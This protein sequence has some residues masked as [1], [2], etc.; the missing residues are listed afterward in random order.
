MPTVNQ[1]SSV[2]SGGP[3]TSVT[4]TF[5]NPVTS[6]NGVIVLI[7]LDTNNIS[8]VTDD[9]SNTYTSVR[10]ANFFG[11]HTGAIYYCSVT[12]NGPTVITVTTSA[13]DQMAAVCLEVWGTLSLDTGSGGNGNNTTQNAGSFTTANVNTIAVGCDHSSSQPSDAD[14][15]TEPGH[16]QGASLKWKSLGASQTINPQWTVGLSSPYAAVAESFKSTSEGPLTWIVPEK[17]SPADPV[18]V[19]GPNPRILPTMLWTAGAIDRTP[20]VPLVL[21]SNPPTPVPVEGNNPRVIPAFIWTGGASD[22]SIWFPPPV[23]RNFFDPPPLN[24]ADPRILCPFDARARPPIGPGLGRK[25]ELVQKVP[26]Q[27]D[28]DFMNRVIIHAQQVANRLNS[29]V[30]RGRLFASGPANAQW[31]IRA[32]AHADTRDPGALDDEQAGFGTGD[33]W[34]NV[35]TRKVWYCYDNTLNAAKWLGPI[36]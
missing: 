11:T 25:R 1:T 19:Q 9:K 18:V 3:V 13:G 23:R 27:T 7:G 26:N 10:T 4:P 5:A 35:N 2:G 30:N 24:K 34:L 31:E 29:L 8:S 15:W 36:G 14:S 22:V 12:T 16:T 17:A 21:R 28:P 32:A 33:A 20:Q 6:G